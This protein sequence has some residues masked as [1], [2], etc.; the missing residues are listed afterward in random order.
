MIMSLPEY[1]NLQLDKQNTAPYDNVNPWPR[2][3]YSGGGTDG[4]GGFRNTSEKAVSAQASR[5][6]PAGAMVPA[7]SS[8]R[9]NEERDGGSRRGGRGGSRGSPTRRRRRQR[10]NGRGGRNGRRYRRRR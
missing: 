3:T 4:S 8:G 7:S 9:R 10:R 5:A 2:T 1:V 6:K